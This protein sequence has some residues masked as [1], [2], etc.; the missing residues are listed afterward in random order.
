MRNEETIRNDNS[1]PMHTDVVIRKQEWA[2][3]KSKYKD[4]TQ[5]KSKSTDK[6]DVMEKQQHGRDKWDMEKLRGGAHMFTRRIP[7]V[8]C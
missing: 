4:M 2:D 8:D 6:D 7:L 3:G 5:G 1:S